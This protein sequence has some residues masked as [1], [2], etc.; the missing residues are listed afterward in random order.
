MYGNSVWSKYS[1]KFFISYDE[2]FHTTT[3]FTYIGEKEFVIEGSVTQAS[4]WH[5]AYEKHDLK[6]LVELF[7]FARQHHWFNPIDFQ[8]TIRVDDFEVPNSI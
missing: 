8:P 2:L 3:K 5:P 4:I 7:E 6:D 1:G